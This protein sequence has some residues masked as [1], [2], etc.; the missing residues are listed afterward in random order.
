MTYEELLKIAG[1]RLEAMDEQI[2]MLS[3]SDVGGKAAYRKIMKV[4]DRFGMTGDM[5]D[6]EA[7]ADALAAVTG[8][9]I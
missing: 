2:Q 4:Y 9:R 1:G 7:V 3:P 5:K 8:S 6:F